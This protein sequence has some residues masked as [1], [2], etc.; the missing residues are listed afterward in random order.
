M[1]EILFRCSS[2]GKLMGAPVSIDPSM[3]TPDVQKILDSKKRTDEEKARIEGLK[4]R[5]L[6]EGAKT[7]VRELVRQEIWGKPWS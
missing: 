1:R 4:L 5:T 3:V 6:S 7:Y 2:I